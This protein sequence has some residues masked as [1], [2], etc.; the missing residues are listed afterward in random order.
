[1]FPCF[2]DEAR[3]TIA[4]MLDELD[5]KN[6]EP[7]VRVNSVDSGLARDDLQ[8][9]LG[10]THSPPSLM[11]P[12]VEEPGHLEWVD[13]PIFFCCNHKSNLH[14]FMLYIILSIVVCRKSLSS[15]YFYE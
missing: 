9:I 2:K 10:A 4:R 6:V 1:M 11:L 5:F 14:I 8:V 3:N 12:K 13:Y 15:A 7:I